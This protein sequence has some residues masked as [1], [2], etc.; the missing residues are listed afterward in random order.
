MVWDLHSQLADACQLNASSLWECTVSWPKVAA[1]SGL[2]PVELFLSTP[3][4]HGRVHLELAEAGPH[5]MGDVG[6]QLRGR[7]GSLAAH[8]KL[9]APNGHPRG[10]G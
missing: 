10:A 1:A 8:A 4:K 6:F 5:E 2:T 7:Q 9:V 3:S